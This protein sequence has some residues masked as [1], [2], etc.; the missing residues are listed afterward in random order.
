MDWQQNYNDLYRKF[1]V[2]A[3]ALRIA[4]K[5]ARENI[6]AEVPIDMEYLAILASGAERDPEGKE[7]LEKW[8]YEAEQ[9][10]KSNKI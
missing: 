8:L 10:L 5:Y 3:N 4:A 1:M 9:K 6:P 7:Y 2:V